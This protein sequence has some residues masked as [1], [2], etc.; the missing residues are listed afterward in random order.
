MQSCGNQE[1]SLNLHRQLITIIFRYFMEDETKIFKNDLDIAKAIMQCDVKVTMQYMYK[2]C[3]PIFK[4]FYNRYFTDCQNCREFIDS[5]YVLIMTP[6]IKSKKSP[7]S[8]FR[9]ESSLKTWLRNAAL[10]YCYH[11]FKKRINTVELPSGASETEEIDLDKFVGTSS[12][13]M[14]ELNRMD[15]E[16]IIKSVLRRMPNRRYSQLLSLYMLDKMT[17]ADIAVKMGMSMPNYYNK[18]KLAKDQYEQ[19]KKELNYE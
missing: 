16:A 6:G 10:T 8:N 15:E 13:D 1:I 4:A 14:S 5:I 17:H 18:R 7:L 11:C 12:I 3:Y 19:I 9:G 2:Y